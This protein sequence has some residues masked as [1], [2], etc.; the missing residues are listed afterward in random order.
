MSLNVLHAVVNKEMTENE[1][2]CN[3]E[4]DVGSQS[5]WAMLTQKNWRKSV[6]PHA[7]VAAQKNLTQSLASLWNDQSRHGAW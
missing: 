3:S 4:Q 7:Q 6:S 1:V 5:S 2:G